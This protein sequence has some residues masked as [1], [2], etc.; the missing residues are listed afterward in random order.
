MNNDKKYNDESKR[1]EYYLRERQSLIE[2][3]RI[4]IQS[5]DKAILTLSSGALALSLTFIKI[6][7]QPFKA[8]VWILAFSWFSLTASIISTMISFL[9]SQRAH[10][11]MIKRVDIKIN[12][13]KYSED[14]KMKID[15]YVK[16]KTILIYILNYTSIILFITGLILLFIF[17]LKNL[18]RMGG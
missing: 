9:C 1:Y 10:R 7:P 6:I 12:P 3:E 5:F 14:Y 4:S 17:I 8:S 11:I 13:Q 16:N 18:T 15:C 2:A